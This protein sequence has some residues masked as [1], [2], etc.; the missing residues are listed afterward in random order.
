M[1]WGV[2]W[3]GAGVSLVNVSLPELTTCNDVMPLGFILITV[4]VPVV[5]IWRTAVSWK[6][7]IS[8]A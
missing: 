3:S 2:E 1:P 6:S 8:L 5:L 4:A 7:K